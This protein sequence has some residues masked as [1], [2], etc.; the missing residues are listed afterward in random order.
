MPEPEIEARLAG[1]WTGYG[2]DG[3][4]RAKLEENDLPNARLVTRHSLPAD[5]VIDN[6]GGG[7]IIS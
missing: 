5:V 3:A 1:R 7:G 6:S 2:L 4:I